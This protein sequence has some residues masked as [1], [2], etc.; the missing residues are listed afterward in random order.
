MCDQVKGLE[1]FSKAQR[2]YPDNAVC[3]GRSELEMTSQWLK[4]LQRCQWCVD[5]HINTEPNL[6]PADSDSDCS[7]IEDE[8]QDD[9]DTIS[10]PY[11]SEDGTGRV[12]SAY[13]SS[14]PRVIR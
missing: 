2:S 11:G 8:Y 13:S 14:I 9:V 7:T 4:V 5:G 1:A 3:Y 12:V 6:A 10:N